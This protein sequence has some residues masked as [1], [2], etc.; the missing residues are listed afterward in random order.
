MV[1]EIKPGRKR[2]KVAVVKIVM[3]VLG[4][5][6]Q[7]VSRL[8]RET[9]EDLEQM[10]DDYKMLYQVLPDGPRLGLVK[11]K[12]G[13]LRYIGQAMGAQEADLVVFF[14]NIEGAFLVFSLQIGTARAYAENRVG[15]IGSLPM[16]MVLTRCLNAVET[17][18]LP[19]LIAQ[20]VVK[21]VPRVPFLRRCYV[22]FVLYV[23][24]VPFGI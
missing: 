9:R 11:D 8:D 15:V 14:K 10:P 2:F 3:F 22:R 19:K 21:R 23:F 17:Y 18:L 1:P 7:T 13:F 20:R 16:V 5:S 6:F 12:K 24:G 4:R